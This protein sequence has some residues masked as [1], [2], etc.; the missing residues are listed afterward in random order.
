MTIAPPNKG[1]SDSL[2]WIAAGPFV[3]FMIP[4]GGLE[5]P[6]GEIRD[7]V[8]YR[9]PTPGTNPFYAEIPG[10]SAEDADGFDLFVDNGTG[11]TV[12]IV[13]AAVNDTTTVRVRLLSSGQVVSGI[14]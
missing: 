6:L 10:V 4:P 3:G 5:T 14:C 13:H 2:S 9:G 8:P 7:S 11:D 12:T 1:T